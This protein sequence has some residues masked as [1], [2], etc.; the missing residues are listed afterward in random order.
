MLQLLLM[1]AGVFYVYKKCPKVKEFIDTHL[2]L[3]KK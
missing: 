2:K 1:G 3:M